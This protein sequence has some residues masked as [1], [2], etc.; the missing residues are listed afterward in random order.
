M[1]GLPIIEREDL[2]MMV[3]KLTEKME[4]KIYV[5]DI[6]AIHRLPNRGDAPATIAAQFNNRD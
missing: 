3:R 4:I 5:T 2:K 1:S 6:C